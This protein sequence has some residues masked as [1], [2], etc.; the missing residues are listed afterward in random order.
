MSGAKFAETQDD[1]SK[2]LFGGSLVATADKAAG[3]YGSSPHSAG[4]ADER[5]S[6]AGPL[7]DA[8]HS[9]GAESVTEATPDQ[10]C[11]EYRLESVSYYR[12]YP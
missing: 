3:P 8:P 7:A 4:E 6:E 9:E 12:I 11:H 10:L 1:G 2:D 5:T